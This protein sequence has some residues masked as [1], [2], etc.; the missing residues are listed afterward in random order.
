MWMVAPSF[1]E[2]GSCDLSIIHTL[3]ALSV[4]LTYSQCLALSL[5]QMVLNFTTRWMYIEDSM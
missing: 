3:T 1:N 2:D 4:A 5:C